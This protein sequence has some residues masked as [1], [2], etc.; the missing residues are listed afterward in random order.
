MNM[1]ETFLG[2]SRISRMNVSE[3]LTEPSDGVSE[4]ILHVLITSPIIV[5]PSF[6]V[7]FT[8]ET[9]SILPET[10]T[11]L[12]QTTGHTRTTCTFTKLHVLFPT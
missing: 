11:F 1:V 10:P 8:P 9:P 4:K 3:D 6:S 2:L 12:G 5:P 7:N